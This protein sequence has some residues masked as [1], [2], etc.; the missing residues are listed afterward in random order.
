[1][2]NEQIHEMAQKLR[3][4]T[5]RMVYEG[6]DGHPGPALSIADIVATLYFDTM[7]IDPGKPE[8]E[9]RDRL[10][11]SKGHSCPIVYAALNERGYFEPKVE[12]FNLRRLHS[13]FQGH[14]SMHS[15][16]GIDMTSGSLGN[17]I[18]IGAGMALAAKAQGKDYYTYVICG[19]GELQEGVCWEGINTASGR[20][21]DNLILFVDRNGWQSYKSVDFTAGHNN[22]AER[23]RAFGWHV[24]EIS[25]HDIGAIKSAITIAKSNRGV[26]SCIVCDCVKGKGVS[27]MEDNNAWHKGVPT[28]DEYAVAVKELGGA[29]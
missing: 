4:E 13:I 6:K 28:D 26:P 5:V 22:V 9:D 16:P 24:Q 25:G 10:I 21:L 7:N 12:H 14:P 2:K 23:I 20:K 29:E 19:D 1:M 27:F 3:L 17:G 18:A 11:L 8:W 15:T